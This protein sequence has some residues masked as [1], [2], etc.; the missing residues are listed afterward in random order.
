MV[1][2]RRRGLPHARNQGPQRARFWRDGV[3]EPVGEERRVYASNDPTAFSPAEVR[4]QKPHRLPH[5][6][7]RFVAKGGTTTSGALRRGEGPASKR[8]DP[9]SAQTRMLKPRGTGS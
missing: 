8:R 7:R 3:I 5:P 9:F 1:A 4:P 6:F 2:Q